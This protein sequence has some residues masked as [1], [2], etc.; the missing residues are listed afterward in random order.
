MKK[1]IGLIVIA[2]LLTIGSFGFAS[3]QH[4]HHHADSTPDATDHDH[5]NM[6]ATPAA[7]MNTSTGAFYFTVTNHGDEADTLVGITSDAAETLEIHSVTMD[8]GVMS[9]EAQPD[10]VEIPAGGELV[11]EPSGYHVMMVGLTESLLDGEEFTATL[12][13]E[14]AGDVEITVPIYAL[15]PDDDAFA[16]PV[17]AGDHLEIG[18]IWA[19]QAPKLDG[20]STPAATPLATPE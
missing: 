20:M 15:A 6:D 4:E 2:A 18:K 14:H 10:G 16:D 12:H 1:R 17:M 3:A 9:M 19:R 5:M 7:N 13:F 11:L 8:N